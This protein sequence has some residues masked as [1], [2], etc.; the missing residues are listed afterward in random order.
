M[1]R[2]EAFSKAWGMM[3]ELKSYYTNCTRDKINEIFDFICNWNDEHEDESELFM[4]EDYNSEEHCLYL[5]L[6]D[7]YIVIED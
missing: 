7:D 3:T 2:E 4:C 5:Y 6:E 1:T